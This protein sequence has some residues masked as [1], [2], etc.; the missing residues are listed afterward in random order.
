ML[1]VI[2]CV[3]SEGFKVK[4]LALGSVVLHANFADKA[5]K[6]LQFGAKSADFMVDYDA[7][8]SFFVIPAHFL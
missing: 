3:T 7:Y 8:S 4:A 2:L 1:S 6:N 5:R